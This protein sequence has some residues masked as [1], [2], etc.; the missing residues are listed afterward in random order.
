[1]TSL[2]FLF[3]IAVIFGTVLAVEVSESEADALRPRGLIAWLTGGNWPAKIGGGLLVVG[4]GALLRYAL[5]NF[6]VAP[7]IKLAVGLITAGALGLAATLTRTGSARRAVSLALGGSAFGVAYLTAYSA[8]ALFHYLESTVGI[9]LLALTAAGAG[10]YAITRSALSLALL[11]MLGAFLAPAFALTDPGPLVV[12]GYYV[13]ACLLTLAMVAARGWRPLIHLSFLFTLGGG[14]FFA[15]TA[16]Y[17]RGDNAAVMLPILLVLAGI[18]VIM[19]LVERHVTRGEWIEKLDIIYALALPASTALAAYLVAPTHIGLS[20]EMLALGAI[21]TA[22]A[23]YLWFVKREGVALHAVIAVLFAGLGAAARFENLPWELI[24]LAFTVAALRLAA[25][26]SESKRLHNTLAGLVPLLGFLHITGSLSPV[27]GSPIFINGRFIER[28]IGAGLLMFAGHICRR[29]RQSLDTLLWTVGIGWALITVGSELVRWDLV[30]LPLLLHWT[31]L[32]SA[33]LLTFTAPR[34]LNGGRIVV[35]LSIAAAVTASW[36]AV[37]SPLSVS[38]TSLAIAPL[39]LTA[40]SM[41]DPEMDSETRT[42][43]M[44][45]ALLAPITPAT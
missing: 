13:G 12:Y 27:P 26:R 34:R 19:P 14:V 31:L 16:H 6:D 40:L 35:F 2:I 5:I 17:Y 44:L 45:A 18:H 33:L 20:N 11:S 42:G 38:W 39:A 15:W 37:K 43:R 30:S 23:A 3:A 22:A 32:L 1:M 9:G 10:V 21:W 7:P 4:I 28:L 41:R 24:A 36:A 25:Q 8:F 29:V